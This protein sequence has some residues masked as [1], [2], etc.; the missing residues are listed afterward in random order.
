MLISLIFD[1]DIME[2]DMEKAISL[3]TGEV[4]CALCR[5][6]VVLTA[7]ARGVRPLLLWL[8]S[9][10]CTRGFSA[11]DRVVG[12][13][14]A[15]L[16]RL[17]GVKAVYARVMSEPAAQVLRAGG[18]AAYPL[19]LVPGIINRAGDGPCPFE[20]AVLSIEDPQ[21]ALTAIRTKMKA[22]SLQKDG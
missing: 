12:R 1:G 21:E 9:G 17:L 7:T 11:A 8:D 2:K 10:V 13:G 22:L 6:D 14:A 16:Y 4:T 3:L 19:K 20:A 18:I 15:F 5:E